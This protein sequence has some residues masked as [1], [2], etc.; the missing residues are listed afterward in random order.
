MAF[1]IITY[2]EWTNFFQFQ[3][4][5]NRACG[6]CSV[7]SGINH[8]NKPSDHK[9]YIT[10]NERLFSIWTNLHGAV[11]IAIWFDES[12]DKCIHFDRETFSNIEST[13]IY[14]SYTLVTGRYSTISIQ[15]YA[16]VLSQPKFLYERQ[17]PSLHPSIHPS[18]RHVY[19]ANAYFIK[20]AVKPS[21]DET[22]IQSQS[23]I[24]QK[25]RMG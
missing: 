10:N 17:L 16:H 3:I 19:G 21:N 1:F 15:M 14:H 23:I 9:L 13:N 12:H 20:S 5:G 7:S 25:Y 24:I 18:E 4:H 8:N 11:K 6:M 22:N 2:F